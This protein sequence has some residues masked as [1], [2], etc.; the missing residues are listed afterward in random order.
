MSKLMTRQQLLLPPP[1]KPWKPHKYQQEAVKFLLARQAAALFLDPGLGKTSIVLKALQALKKQDPGTAAV[2]LC[3]LRVAYSVWDS[4]HPYSEVNKWKDFCGLKVVVLHGK[5]KDQ[6]INETADIY[7][8]NFD[9][10]G[11]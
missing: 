3:P 11:S 8:L 4:S 1:P 2:V 10:V 7:V 6:L 5:D 9:E